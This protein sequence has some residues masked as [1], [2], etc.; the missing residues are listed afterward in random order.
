MCVLRQTTRG[1]SV[2]RSHRAALPARV[3]DASFVSSLSSSEWAG[4][5]T[6]VLVIYFLNAGLL[7]GGK[8][9]SVEGNKLQPFF[10]ALEIST[11]MI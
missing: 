6:M 7:S 9:V 10:S 2:G 11:Q 8:R 1:A 5:G 3:S 4:E